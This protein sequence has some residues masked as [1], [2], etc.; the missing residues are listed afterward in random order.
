MHISWKLLAWKRVGGEG[1]GIRPIFLTDC[2]SDGVAGYSPVEAKN[3]FSVQKIDLESKR[4]FTRPHI[5]YIS[6]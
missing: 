2:N 6:T 1:K 5:W 3:F 4:C